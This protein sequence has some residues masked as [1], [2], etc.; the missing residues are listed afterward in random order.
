MSSIHSHIPA[1]FAVNLADSS[2]DETTPLQPKRPPT[3]WRHLLEQLNNANHP[4]LTG[5]YVCLDQVST[6]YQPKNIKHLNQKDYRIVLD[7][8]SIT[9][10]LAKEAKQAMLQQATEKKNER[11]EDAAYRLFTLLATYQP[12]PNELNACP[13]T[14]SEGPTSTTG[15][16]HAQGR[17]P[18]MEDAH[19]CTTLEFT[20]GE[21]T[22]SATLSAIFDGHGGSEAAHYAAKHL[23]THLKRRLEQFNRPNLSDAGIW[24]ALK[25]AL[26]DTSRSYKPGVGNYSHLAGATANVCMQIGRDLWTA[27]VGDSRALLLSKEGQ[28]TQLSEDAKPGAPRYQTDIEDRG[29]AVF[30]PDV[31]RVDGMLAV[32]RALGDHI[33]MGGVSARPKIVKYQLPKDATGYT[34]V[35]CCDG[36]FDVATSDQ[37]GQLVRYAHEAN[38]DTKDIAQLVVASAY[39]ARSMDN[40]SAIVRTL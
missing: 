39:L 9:R 5:Q 11:F 7:S 22:H 18:S 35:Q 14:A 28:V 17:R 21:T 3:S 20:I 2:D 34:L 13:I 25:L 8:K 23:T 16:A 32:A 31:A 15:I 12:A 37:V 30:Y 40:L 24:N 1:T 6:P 33:L 19:L 38:L 36:V 27:N 4:A 29:H 26:V 10:R